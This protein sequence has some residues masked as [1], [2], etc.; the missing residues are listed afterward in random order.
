MTHVAW[1]PRH[2]EGR[3]RSMG[4]IFNQKTGDHIGGLLPSRSGHWAVVAVRGKS[5]HSPPGLTLGGVYDGEVLKPVGRTA[6]GGGIMGLKTL[7]VRGPLCSGLP[8][9]F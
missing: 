2:H 7:K 1:E 6:L 4:A 3:H 8:G 5:S 9:M